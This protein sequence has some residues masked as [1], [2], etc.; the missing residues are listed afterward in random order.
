MSYLLCMGTLEAT[1]L[2]KI[3][4]E[5]ELGHSDK[6]L[7]RKVTKGLKAFLKY[8]CRERHYIFL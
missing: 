6:I 1:Q 2:K 3:D 4:G 5:F 7:Q 8:C